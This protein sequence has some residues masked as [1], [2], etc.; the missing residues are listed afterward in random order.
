[1]KCVGSAQGGRAL[2]AEVGVAGPHQG[3]RY[4]SGFGVPDDVRD[5]HADRRASR[6]RGSVRWLLKDVS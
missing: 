2:V 4:G 3:V 6:A 5:V 1:M